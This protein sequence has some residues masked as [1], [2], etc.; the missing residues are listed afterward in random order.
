MS[1]VAAFRASEEEFNRMAV[2]RDVLGE[3]DAERGGDDDP[4]GGRGMGE[5][6]GD[7]SRGPPPAVEGDGG[8]RGGVA[9]GASPSPPPAE[10]REEFKLSLISSRRARR[11]G[12]RMADSS[13]VRSSSESGS[14]RGRIFPAEAGE[15]DKGA[16]ESE[17]ALLL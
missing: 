11:P 9:A 17:R 12:P 2:E 13:R 7:E 1:K 14:M 10:A 15:G 16:A 5:R 3:G 4:G 8:P 6:S